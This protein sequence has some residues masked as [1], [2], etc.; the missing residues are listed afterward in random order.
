MYSPEAGKQDRLSCDNFKLLVLVLVLWKLLLRVTCCHSSRL[1]S[2][3]DPTSIELDRKNL[4][5]AREPS[6]EQ[7]SLPHD[8]TNMDSSSAGFLENEPFLI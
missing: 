6:I 8:V 5:E 1:E 3:I 7:T 4:S 2:G